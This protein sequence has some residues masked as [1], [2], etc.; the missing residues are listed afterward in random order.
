MASTRKTPNY[1]LSQFDSSDKPTWLT[2]YNGDM[3]KID[4]QMKENADA[5][6]ENTEALAKI[7]DTVLPTGMVIP[8]AGSSVPD[9][10]ILCDGRA[11]SRSAYSKLFA[12]IGTT[13]GPGDGRTTFGVPDL[14]DRVVGGASSSNTLA[15]NAGS[16]NVTLAEANIPQ[17][18]VRWALKSDSETQTAQKNAVQPTYTDRYTMNT[19]GLESGAKDGRVVPVN[20]RQ[21]TTYLNYIIKT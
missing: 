12:A 15:S 6:A 5:I 18:C 14:R 3:G 4:A 21:K 1:D 13:Y 2:D 16:D 11:V 10:W 19:N 8:F 17:Y 7:A 9:G 20:V